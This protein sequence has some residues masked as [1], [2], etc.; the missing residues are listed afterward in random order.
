MTL[1]VPW[2]AVSCGHPPVRCALGAH[3]QTCNCCGTA[4][5][6]RL[7]MKYF[8]WHTSRCML[9]RLSHHLTLHWL[10]SA[11]NLH[12]FFPFYFQWRFAVF[13]SNFLS[14]G[15]LITIYR[16]IPG[17]HFQQQAFV[18]PIIKNIWAT[19]QADTYLHQARIQN[20]QQLI[21][22]SNAS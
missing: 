4:S 20:F 6:M 16:K 17:F 3:N 15:S 13:A 21:W 2:I 11:E 7:E 14:S 10:L 12:L 8:L 18:P 19:V 1:R 5:R 9:T 22:G